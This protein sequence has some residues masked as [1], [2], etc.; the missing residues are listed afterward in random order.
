LICEGQDRSERR[1]EEE[2]GGTGAHRVDVANVGEVHV[3]L[4]KLLED[5]IVVNRLWSKVLVSPELRRAEDYS[6]GKVSDW[7][8]V[9][10]GTRENR[11]H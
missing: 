8:K 6:S 4:R 5:L 10:E 9:A 3:I 1:E 2:R 11:T 7:W